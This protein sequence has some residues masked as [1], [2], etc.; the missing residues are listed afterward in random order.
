MSDD[1]RNSQP[2]DLVAACVTSVAEL[3][4]LLDGLQPSQER[5][6]LVWTLQVTASTPDQES[7]YIFESTTSTIQ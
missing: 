6:L 2:A 4:A 3:V 7:F 1:S 5:P